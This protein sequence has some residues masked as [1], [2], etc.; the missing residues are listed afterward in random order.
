L[1][2][3]TGLK[4]KIIEALSYGT[5]VICTSESMVGFPNENDN[6]IIVENDPKEFAKQIIKLTSS[7]KFLDEQSKKGKKYF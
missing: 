4:V 5:P 1:H 2:G 7:P 6:G 3:G